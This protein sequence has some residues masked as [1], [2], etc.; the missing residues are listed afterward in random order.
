MSKHHNAIAKEF[1]NE[2][3]KTFELIVLDNDIEGVKHLL[4][5]ETIYKNHHLSKMLEF[6]VQLGHV[7]ISKT[8]IEC[9]AEVNIHDNDGW[10]PLHNAIAFRKTE[11]AK[12]LIGYGADINSE[13][14]R[15]FTAIYRAIREGNLE[16]V[17][18]LV[19]SGADIN[20]NMDSIG[21]PLYEAASM[22][23]LEVTKFLLERNN[24]LFIHQFGSTLLENLTIIGIDNDGTYYKSFLL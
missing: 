10:G 22:R 16:I 18:L 2:I 8:L 19:E 7:E 3:K 4:N 9:G 12:M 11:T 17:K 5:D 6:S 21:Q 24:G 23:N 13:S 15:G 1:K 14:S 20:K